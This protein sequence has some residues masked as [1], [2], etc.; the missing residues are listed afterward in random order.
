MIDREPMGVGLGDLDRELPVDVRAQRR[1]DEGLRIADEVVLQRVGRVVEH[2]V[3][4][5]AAGADRRGG[6][7]RRGGIGRRLA[8]AP[9]PR[10]RPAPPGS[11]PTTTGR[12]ASFGRP[13]SVSTSAFRAR[14]PDR[15]IRIPV[16]PDHP[17]LLALE[18]LHEVERVLLADGRPELAAQLPLDPPEQVEL[19]VVGLHDRGRRAPR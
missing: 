11:P 1:L 8:A 16:R 4:A 18:V 10:S 12:S 9:R 15:L 2:P 6:A 5:A 7:A 17:L 19:G 13:C 3:Q 14:I